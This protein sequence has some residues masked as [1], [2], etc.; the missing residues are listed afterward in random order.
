MSRS[1]TEQNCEKLHLLATAPRKQYITI[2]TEADSDLIRA[3]LEVLSNVNLFCEPLTKFCV[4]SLIVRLQ[5]RP[6]SR[7]RLLLENQR[8]IQS[9]LSR[10]FLAAIEAEAAVAIINYEPGYESSSGP[11]L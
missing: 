3:L 2:I 4:A 9:I 11:A 5:T 8:I 7:I 10:V 1:L 6:E